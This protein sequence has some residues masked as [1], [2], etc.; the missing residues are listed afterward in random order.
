[1]VPDLYIGLRVGFLLWGNNVPSA[2]NVFS[3]NHA[4]TK[5][6][7]LLLSEMR[8]YEEHVWSKQSERNRRKQK[9][10]VRDISHFVH[11]IRPC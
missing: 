9:I 2:L 3:T 5:H 8:V 4:V 1:M 11:F 10:T 6:Y 7:H